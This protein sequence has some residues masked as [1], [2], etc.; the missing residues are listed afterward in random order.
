MG[1]ESWSRGE[2]QNQ[3]EGVEESGRKFQKVNSKLVIHFAII[4]SFG[5]R[6]TMLPLGHE[7]GGEEWWNCW[8]QGASHGP[9]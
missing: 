6:Q 4:N 7:V 2:G 5:S 1:L 9:L 8:Q 3:D